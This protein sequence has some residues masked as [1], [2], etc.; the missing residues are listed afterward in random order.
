MFWGLSF[1][2]LAKMYGNFSQDA[3]D[4]SLQNEGY[5]RLLT[6]F[7]KNRYGYNTRFMS[8]FELF[9]DSMLNERFL[10]ESTLYY[11]DVMTGAE[12]QDQEMGL[13]GDFAASDVQN[14][15]H[16]VSEHSHESF[17]ALQWPDR[18]GTNF[19]KGDDLSCYKI[20][21]KKQ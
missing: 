19:P 18:V 2:C 13:A 20:L 5:H 17:K 12:V 21:P 3:P 16:D 1:L 6:I 7:A 14:L 9:L 15:V 11:N 10:D 8:D 4:N